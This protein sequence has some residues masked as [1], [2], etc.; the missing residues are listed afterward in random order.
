[1][2]ASLVARWRA[3][4]EIAA[5]QH[6]LVSTRQLHAS[7]VGKGSIEKAHRSGRLWRIHRGVYAVGHPALSQEGKWL[8]AVLACGSGAAL[9]HRSAASLWQIRSAELAR[10][11]VTVPREG[12][13]RRPGTLIHTSPL[14]PGEVVH[15]RDIPVTSPAR[16]AVDLAHALHDPDQVHRLLREMQFRRLFDTTALEVAN[17]RRP[18]AVL[19]LTVADLRPTRS[20]HEDAFKSKVLRRYRIPDPEYNRLVQGFTVD[21]HWP[22]AR[23][24]VEIDGNNHINPAMLQA[25]AFRN[26]VLQA[27]GVMVLHYTRT[28]IDRRHAQVAAQVLAALESRTRHG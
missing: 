6:G 12:T 4:A 8:A 20:P 25:D 10:V 23:L 22:R 2:G 24:V 21:C 17:H 18:S 9:S 3:V 13:Y 7:G 26:N 16:T 14:P 5:R 27:A 28:D 11:E 15:K 1:M 19:S